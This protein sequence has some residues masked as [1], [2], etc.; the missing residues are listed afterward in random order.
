MIKVAAALIR[1]NNCI[2]VARRPVNDHLAGL[3]E[4]PGGKIENGETPEEC[5]Y[6]E[7]LEE[8]RV[9]IKVIGYF[10]DSTY[11][12]STK[13]IHL[14][15]FWAA[16]IDGEVQALVHDEVK[17]VTLDELSALPFAPADIP[18][19]KKIRGEDLFDPGLK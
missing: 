5:L 9:K 19:V 14:L 18:I 1:K 13:S 17:W 12:Y 8:L 4:F 7:I 11:V 10:A 16:L 3:W 2:L 6:R 15:T